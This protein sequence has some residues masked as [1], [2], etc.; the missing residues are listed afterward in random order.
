MLPLGQWKV[1]SGKRPGVITFRFSCIRGR[2]LCMWRCMFPYVW[3]HVYGVYLHVG[4]DIDV[5]SCFYALFT[6]ARSQ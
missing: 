4:S 1:M 3:V 5:G 2:V 6:E